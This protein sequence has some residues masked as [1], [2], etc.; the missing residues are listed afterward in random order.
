MN[1]ENLTSTGFTTRWMLIYIS[2][3]CIKYEYSTLFATFVRAL[4]NKL[5]S[6]TWLYVPLRLYVQ[7]VYVIDVNNDKQHFTGG[8]GRP[9]VTALHQFIISE[10]FTVHVHILMKTN[11][12]NLIKTFNGTCSISIPVSSDNISSLRAKTPKASK[13][14]VAIKSRVFI[15]CR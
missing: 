5:Q 15:L 14:N 11:F 2:T 9:L 13:N 4:S 12:T 7:Y 10:I 8:K 1:I 6:A 3:S